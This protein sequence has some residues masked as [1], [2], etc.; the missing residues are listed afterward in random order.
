MATEFSRCGNDLASQAES[1]SPGSAAAAHETA[2]PGASIEN[3]ETRSYRFTN[4]K[5]LRYL[6]KRQI[7]QNRAGASTRRPL[8]ST[9][10]IL[11]CRVV[12]KRN[13]VSPIEPLRCSLKPA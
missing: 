5:V 10:A 1:P 7:L 11:G 13:Y 4:R 9:A 6:L 2:W 12:R 3:K 8:V